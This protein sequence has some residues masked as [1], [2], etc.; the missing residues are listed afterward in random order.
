MGA[1][2]AALAAIP[3]AS[4]VATAD[5]SDVSGTVLDGADGFEGAKVY[6]V[7]VANESVVDTAIS[8]SDGAYSLDANGSD[9]VDATVEDT[10]NG[11]RTDDANPFL[12]I[13][14]S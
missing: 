10:T 6:A 12:D 8:G 1:A 7:D 4:V 5:P 9:Q 13:N 11:P 2:S 14:N 3:G